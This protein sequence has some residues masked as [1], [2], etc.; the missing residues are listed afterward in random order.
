MHSKNKV[1]KFTKNYITFL[2]ASCKQLKAKEIA[3]D[4]NIY[5]NLFYYNYFS[6]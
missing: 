6:V 5:S 1:F 4:F 3:P 2:L